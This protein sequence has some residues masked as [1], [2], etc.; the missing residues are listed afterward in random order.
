MQ[1]IIYSAIIVGEPYRGSCLFFIITRRQNLSKIRLKTCAV[2]CVWYIWSIFVPRD[3]APFGQPRF[4]VLTKR[5][6]ASGDENVSGHSGVLARSARNRGHDKRGE[7]W[8]SLITCGS[9]HGGHQWFSDYS[10]G[11]QE[12][13]MCSIMFANGGAKISNKSYGA[14]SSSEV[15]GKNC[16]LQ[17]A[18]LEKRRERKL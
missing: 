11:R 13:F 15:L 1:C 2:D 4:L 14:F 12:I 3:R 8:I 5:S 17:L 10:R 18:G 7:I 16:R 6:V 9:I